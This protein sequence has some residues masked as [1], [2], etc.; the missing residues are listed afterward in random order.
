MLFGLAGDGGRGTHGS[1]R[2]LNGTC[3]SFFAAHIS[4]HLPGYSHS[5]PRRFVDWDG[6]EPWRFF[7]K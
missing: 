2:S 1:Q 4:R 7:M 5:T 6:Q 3:L